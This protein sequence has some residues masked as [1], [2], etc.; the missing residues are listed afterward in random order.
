MSLINLQNIPSNLNFFLFKQQLSIKE[1]AKRINEPQ[2]TILAIARHK[3]KKCRL[4]LC[5]KIAE[6]IGMDSDTLQT[7]L[8]EH[9]QK[10]THYKT[11]QVI[12]YQTLSHAHP[13]T[14]GLYET[15]NTQALPGSFVVHTDA[16]FHFFPVI[17]PAC[18]VVIAPMKQLDQ[19]HN[20][21]ILLIQRD[22]QALF[23]LMEIHHRQKTT[24]LCLLTADLKV[25]E[26][27][28]KSDFIKANPLHGKVIEIRHD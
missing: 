28:L 16:T 13:D 10:Q 5:E 8:L 9:D 24:I 27:Y 17:P 4:E 3:T 7:S 2:S 23:R 21:D 22:H 12:H 14:T 19:L 15:A 6:A 11:L 18:R 25:D 26:V 1:F 20:H